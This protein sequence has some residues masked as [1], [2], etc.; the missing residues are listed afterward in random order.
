MAEL[1]TLARSANLIRMQRRILTCVLS[2]FL[3][4]MQH[5]TLR[6]ALDH[7]GAQLQ[8]LEHS[9]LERPTG[10]TCPE[11]GLLASGANAI[12]AA[13]P[14]LLPDLTTHAA[15]LAPLRG[16]ITVAGFPLY[17]S[18]APPPVLRHT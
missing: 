16:R 14:P 17:R 4:L 11:C 10:D 13:L 6:H 1:P 3:L 12:A 8:R 2:V 18:R 15:A 9:A 7:A 5:E